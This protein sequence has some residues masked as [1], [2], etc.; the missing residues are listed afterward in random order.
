MFGRTRNVPWPAWLLAAGALAA[1]IT[2]LML[3]APQAQAHH[4]DD[5]HE[6]ELRCV[7]NQDTPLLTG[8]VNE[9]DDFTLQAKWRNSNRG[10]GSWKAVW[11]TNEVVEPAI[12]EAT[13]DVDFEPEHDETHSKSRTYD[14][15]NHTFHTI[16]DKV[17]E[18]DQWFFAG[19]SAIR[20]SGGTDRPAQYCFMKLVEDDTL[21]VTSV[22]VWGDPDNGSSYGAGERI[23]VRFDYNGKVNVPHNGAIKLKLRDEA[24]TIHEREATYNR[25]L[26]T[27][28]R[29]VYDYV[30]QTGD[31][32][33][34]KIT[35]DRA[36]LNGDVV[37][38]NTNG[39]L[40]DVAAAFGGVSTLQNF[41]QEDG[42]MT[43]P[44]H[45]GV[46]TRPK[47]T[48][49]GFSS[50]PGIDHTIKEGE[51]EQWTIRGTYRLGEPVEITAV[52][53]QPVDVTG[54]A[55][56]S[57][58]ING[59]LPSWRGANY[60]RGSGTNTLVFRYI[61]KASD[62][63][64]DGMAID[65]G[66]SGSGM[67]GNGT[68]TAAGTG[69]EASARYPRVAPS[70]D[71]KV[72]GRPFVLWTEV[73]SEP[74]EDSTYWTGEKIVIAL[75]YNTE[76]DVSGNPTID[77]DFEDDVHPAGYQ[78]LRKAGY[79]KG[80]GSKKLTFIYEV[81]ADD[82]DANGIRLWLGGGDFGL[83]GGTVTAAGTNVEA[84]PWY[85]G[86]RSNPDHKVD[87]S[88]GNRQQAG[89]TSLD[90]TSDPGTDGNYDKGDEI[91]VTVNFSSDL[92]ITAPEETSDDNDMNLAVD[93]G[94]E[95]VSFYYDNDEGEA[96]Q[97]V[98]EYIVVDGDNALQGIAIP[99]DAV[100][101]G[102]YTV[103]NELGNAA[104]LTHEAVPENSD[105]R[106]DTAA[107]TVTGV[108]LRSFPSTNN[109]YNTDEDIEVKLTFSEPVTITGTP[110][111]TIV[112]DGT[113][114]AASY[115]RAPETNKAIF[116]Y[117]VELGDSSSLG[118][119]IRANSLTLNGGTIVD[120]AGHAAKLAHWMVGPNAAHQVNGRDRTPPTITSMAFTSDPGSDS[121]YGLADVVEITVY[122]S[123][124]VI[125]TG[126][127]ELHLRQDPEPGTY[128]S[129]RTIRA[130]YHDNGGN[131]IQ[132][133][134]TVEADD[135]ASDGL[136]VKANGLKRN[137][138]T[139]RDSDS[140]KADLASSF[141]GPK[142]GH[143]MNGSKA[144][145]GDT[146]DQEPD[147]TAPTVSTVAI[148]ST[149][150]DDNTYNTG[151]AITI[152]VTF[153]EAVTVTGSPQLTL[154]V[155]GT[156]RVAGLE[157]SDGPNAAFSYTVQDGESDT[158]GV[159]IGADAVSLNGG[160]IK[161]G[162]D[163]D[164]DLT[165]G[166]VAASA[167]HKVDGSDTTN[168][169]ISAIRFTSDPGAD[170]HYGLGDVIE[171][172]VTFDEDVSV[173]AAANGDTPTLTLNLDPL[174]GG[175]GLRDVA[176][177]Y[178]ATD[179]DALTFT[180]TVIAQDRANDSAAIAANGIS[181]NGATIQDEAGNDAVLRNSLYFP[182]TAPLYEYHQVD[183]SRGSDTQ[184]GGV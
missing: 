13:E 166:A 80:S 36:F 138:G 56:V 171:A 62:R 165:H 90:I 82:S 145:S 48:H 148:T 141:F 85:S 125:V 140:N 60:H 102:G 64:E 23:R 97:L 29:P 110:Q 124:T 34:S 92:T 153:D 79:E 91:E 1:L 5:N 163:N 121:R 137:G 87:G 130:A 71:Q 133:R 162:A 95:S 167:S 35:I 57:F 114:F 4:S 127:P 94:D 6:F 55:G 47:V 38:V 42:Q 14:K 12:S 75:H 69:L 101:L 26:T 28:K 150:G 132:F 156:D 117:T 175:S 93:I 17:W 169:A 179:G 66:G 74:V 129:A 151:D 9:G 174:P 41:E 68:I 184:T 158:D 52:Y 24:G 128:G 65:L 109:T 43:E 40:S 15:F 99:E 142:G 49:L 10:V 139:I 53:D 134:H 16:E 3:S 123:E 131:R 39:T 2:V 20:P 73:Q 30:V 61:V 54:G 107:P 104:A 89:I 106:V 116:T 119:E 70:E 152:T 164:A 98:F 135:R 8:S 168:P 136:S 100:N 154:D 108:E 146:V 21:R 112:L 159:S 81:Q 113:D 147:T 19:F 45:F 50:E 58:R 32:T 126:S 7:Q 170:D 103:E 115:D 149:A 51:T 111:V 37:G 160:T 143:T 122:F 120:G 83:A 27:N 178:D 63:D 25:S 86:F 76:V 78:H 105:H 155:G 31:P 59:T 33:A 177:D 181:L 161:D 118:V 88:A 182:V 157:S 44:A 18:G 176:M 72:D 84:N 22:R 144:G 180:Y 96:S 11:D 173:T 77:L 67:Y 46:D 183:G 172:T